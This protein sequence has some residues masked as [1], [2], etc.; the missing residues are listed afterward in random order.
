MDPTDITKKENIEEALNVCLEVMRD[1]TAKPA[2]RLNASQTVIKTMMAL[3]KRDDE[4][5]LNNNSDW[6]GF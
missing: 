4:H 3:V 1:E 2:V 6:F 5:G